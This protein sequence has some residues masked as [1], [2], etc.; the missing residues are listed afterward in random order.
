M[1]KN[2]TLDFFPEI[3]RDLSS[4]HTPGIFPS[5]GIRDFIKKGYITANTRIQS[6]QIQPASLDLRLGEI[7]YQVRASF[8]PGT[9]STV[10]SKI[11]NLLW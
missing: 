4:F 5:Q 7:A 9:S 11:K 8:L 3:S 10:K 2:I 1:N 6:E